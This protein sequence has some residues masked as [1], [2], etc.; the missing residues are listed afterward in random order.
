MG[1]FAGLE[2]INELGKAIMRQVE[3]NIRSVI[4]PWDGNIDRQAIMTMQQGI[5]IHVDEPANPLWSD[6]PAETIESWQSGYK[7]AADVSVSI[8]GLEGDDAACKVIYETLDVIRKNPPQSVE[9][10]AK[11]DAELA[12]KDA[13]AA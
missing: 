6:V 8:D 11:A 1:E 4:I 3:A 13:E 9:W 10:K 2:D 7:S 5:V 12:K